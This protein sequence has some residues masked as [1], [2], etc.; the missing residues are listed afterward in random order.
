MPEAPR[1]ELVDWYELLEISPRAS[2][3]VIRAA[4]RALARSNHPDLN[5]SPEASLRIRQLNAA[6]SVL[7]NAEDRARYDL[8]CARVRRNGRAS[9]ANQASTLTTLSGWKPSRKLSASPAMAP[10]YTGERVAGLSAHALLGLLVVAA[11][12]TFLL[13]VLWVALDTASDHNSAY[14]GPTV[15]WSGH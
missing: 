14:G 8:E 5:A 10:Y 3:D 7:S 12:A 9:Q 6:Y 13:I 4:Y 15:V 2:L 11:L 1:N